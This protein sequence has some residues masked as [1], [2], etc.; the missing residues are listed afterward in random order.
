MQYFYLAVA[1]VNACPDA[2]RDRRLPVVS[3]SPLTERRYSFFHS[4]NR[5]RNEK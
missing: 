2:G 1:P 3:S 4:V 5:F